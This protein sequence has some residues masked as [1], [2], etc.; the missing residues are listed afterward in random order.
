MSALANLFLFAVGLAFVIVGG[1]LFVS[2][3]VAIAERAR[4]PK[5][6]V[7]GTLVSLATTCPELAV[8]A[9]AS[10]RGNASIALGNAVG[11]VICNIG[12]I[13]G[14]LCILRPMPVERSDFR[15]PSLFMLGSG[16]L[17]AILTLPLRLGRAAGVLLIGCAALYL[18]LD[19][20]RH[21]RRQREPDCAAG[22]R[23]GLWKSVAVFVLGAALVIAGSRLLTD[24]AV[25]LAKVLGVPKIVIGL[26]LVALGTSL[27]ELVTA[28]TSARK[29]VPEL[30]LG[31]VVGANIMNMTLIT[32]VA[33]AIAPLEMERTTQLYNLP[34]MLA[35]CAALLAMAR[36]GGQLT[37]REGFAFLG[38]Y[39][40]YVAGL[41]AVSG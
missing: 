3:S 21:A 12:V 34:A 6:L 10:L 4:L 39:A 1:D 41:A 19:Y 9:T 7:G 33:A 27:P 2:S 23:M 15:F 29:G 28:V 37:R 14:V 22:G 24:G 30:S 25:G 32:G 31:N 8:S 36:T 35:F 40:A 18:A 26:T 38:L 5:V 11:S 17:L 16:V 13:I 20:L